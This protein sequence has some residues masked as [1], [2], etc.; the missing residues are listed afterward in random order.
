MSPLPPRTKHDIEP[1]LPLLTPSPL[2]PSPK[3]DT[4]PEQGYN[5][6]NEPLNALKDW[7]REHS[8]HNYES[9]SVEKLER[10]QNLLNYRKKYFS[11]YNLTKLKEIASSLHIL[12]CNSLNRNELI[13]RS[14]LV[15]KK[16][17]KH[18]ATDRWDISDLS[19]RYIRDLVMRYIDET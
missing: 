9:M 12:D 17:L 1:I 5:Y 15:H 16:N 8:M 3:H 4:S 10:I 2:T 19:M 7:A 11:A 14:E 18:Y 13:N 6:D